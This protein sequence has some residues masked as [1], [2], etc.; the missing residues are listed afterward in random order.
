MNFRENILKN[1]MMAAMLAIAACGVNAKPTKQEIADID[2]LEGTIFVKDQRVSYSGV[3]SS[4]GLQFATFTRDASTKQGAVRLSGSFNI[5]LDKKLDMVYRLKLGVIDGFKDDAV[6]A[7]PFNAFFSSPQGSAPTKSVI[8]QPSSAPGY[9][10]V[11]GDVD[12]DVLGA[13]EAIFRQKKLVVG[14][15][16]ATG[17]QDVTTTIDLTVVEST[18]GDTKVS[19]KHSDDAVNTFGSCVKFLANKLK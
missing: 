11:A 10:V 2:L 6:P 8:T 15:N 7:A 19:R 17:Q 14:F 3:I 4:C 13:L 1:S 12:A 9:A 18:M 5:M 16:R